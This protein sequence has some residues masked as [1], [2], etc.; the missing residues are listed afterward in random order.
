MKKLTSVMVAMA[1]MALVPSVIQANEGPSF[2]DVDTTNTHYEAI[3][4]MTDRGIIQGYQEVHIV[5]VLT[6]VVVKSQH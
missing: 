6:L 3:E 4:R 2:F 5:R 1:A